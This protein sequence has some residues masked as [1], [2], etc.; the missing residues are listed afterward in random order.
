MS[1]PYIPLYI[2]D[3][4]ADTVHLSMMEDGAYNRLLRL[5]WR[6][7]GCSIPDDEAW[8]FRRMRAQTDEERGAVLTVIGEFFERRAG[9]IFSPRL[10]REF[11]KADETSRKRSD[12]GK[13]GGRPKHIENK[14]EGAKPGSSQDKAGTKHPEP[15]PEPDIEDSSLRSESSNGGGGIAQAR[16]PEPGLVSQI[17][18]ALG[19]NDP[20]STGWPKYW[21]SADAAI[22]ASR[23]ITDL[24]LTASEVVQVAV[25]NAKAHGAPAQGPKILTKHMQA[26]AAARDSPRLAPAAA[27]QPAARPTGHG[28]KIDPEKFT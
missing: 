22:I 21:V 14:E 20:A 15:D 11:K 13:R 18:D 1:L 25:S 10:V 19:F 26:Y 9:R 4:E 6:T 16:E 7:P 8:I 12:A 28:I 27:P 3:Y 24:G 23:W 5:M 17:A 2:D